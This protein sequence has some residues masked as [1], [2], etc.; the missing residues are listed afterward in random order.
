MTQVAPDPAAQVEAP[1]GAVSPGRAIARSA[2]HLV[3]GQ[4]A[5]T[6]LAIA[7]SAA[8]GRWLGPS[9]FGILYFVTTVNGFSYVVVDWGQSFYVVREVAA[10]PGKARALLGSALVMRVAGTGL[11]VAL[12]T[13]VVVT[14]GYPAPT[15]GYTALAIA[16]GLPALLATTYS[17]VFRGKERMD[18]S[19]GVDVANRLLVVTITIAALALGGRVL[20]AVV[21]QGVAGVGA[22]IVGA[23]LYRR[24]RLSRPRG[25]MATARELLVGGTPMVAMSIAI[26][27]LPNIDAILLSKLAPG[28]AVGWYGAARNFM[29]VLTA[30]A[31]ILGT[32]AYPRLSRAVHDPAQ[33]RTELRV[34]LR[35]LL[36]LG[37]LGAVGTY[38][39]ADLAVTLVYGKARYAPAV[40]ILQLF[41]PVLL[42]LFVDMPL[43]GAILAAG[44]S[45]S[46]AAVKLLSVLVGAVLDF[47]FI[48]FFQ[49]RLGNGGLGV[50][51]SFCISELVMVIAS[52]AMI[53]RGAIDRSSVVDMFRSLGT[54]VATVLL[55]RALPTMPQLVEL[56][57]CLVVFAI[58]AWATGLVRRRDLDLLQEVVRRRG[59]L[60][61]T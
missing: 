12:G 3:L 17:L 61:G 16:M 8:L 47:L 10:H 23:Y 21:A 57:L 18:F 41:A 36:V 22:L 19:A 30:P 14:L 44:K 33:F 56:P 39:F 29:S 6:V 13:A 20:S 28:S 46:F 53:P 37:A 5:M 4:A 7:L 52:L 60:G 45:R 43:G 49:A 34:A 31:A 42:L 40:P 38:F 59:A 25:S 58:L 9:D 27:L 11:M 50:T 35:P 24:L 32:A 54:A 1:A 55:V 15:P 51:L 48:S 2:F 26:A